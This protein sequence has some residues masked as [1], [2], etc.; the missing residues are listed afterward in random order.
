MNK[1]IKK[2]LLKRNLTPRPIPE[3]EID[4]VRKYL[5]NKIYHLCNMTEK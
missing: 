4:T 2:K 5:I 3:E 1:R